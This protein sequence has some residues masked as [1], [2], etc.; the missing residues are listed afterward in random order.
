MAADFG[1]CR[2]EGGVELK[3]GKKPE[4]LLQRIFQMSTEEG[5]IVLDFFLGSGTTVAVAHKMGR[6]YI[7][8]EQI[9][10]SENDCVVRLHNVVNG[11]QTG[12]SKAANWQGG[13]DFIYC[14][15]M[16]F[17]E[18]F[19][20]RIQAA[21]SSNE[22]VQVWQEMVENSFLN[23]YVNPEMPEE[24]VNEFIA[25]GKEAGGLEKQKHLLVELLDK[26]QLYVH[27]SEIDDSQFN[28][29]E[30]D[31]ALNRAFYGE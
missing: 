19:V 29:S 30:D 10:Y 13:G 21:Q 6:Q 14:E 3:S 16:K 31:K 8:I 11:D 23:W 25:L 20:E 22:L 5:D 15:L 9:D 26:N 7:G 2:N 24:A 17:N 18:A 28:I 12:I 1:N 4:K 27:L